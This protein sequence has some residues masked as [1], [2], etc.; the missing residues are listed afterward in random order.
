M[1][2]WWNDTDREICNTPRKMCA[3]AMLSTIN[4]T[5]IGLGS[6]LDLFIERLVTNNLSHDMV[7]NV[8]L[9]IHLIML[10]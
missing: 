6:N 1:E 3:S 10:Y 8:Y 5:Q 9:L 7:I 2:N 4:P